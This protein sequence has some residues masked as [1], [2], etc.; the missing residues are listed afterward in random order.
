MGEAGAA[1]PGGESKHP[2]D[3]LV[4]GSNP[5]PRHPQD[6]AAEVCREFIARVPA[7]RLTPPRQSPTKGPSSSKS[8]LQA[9]ILVGRPVGVWAPAGVKTAKAEVAFSG[10]AIT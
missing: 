5:T 8:G 3:E 6:R 7:P 9:G 10:A 4:M 2:S 1:G